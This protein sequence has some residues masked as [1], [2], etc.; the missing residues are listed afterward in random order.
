M[1]ILNITY[2]KDFVL[3]SENLYEP[4]PSNNNDKVISIDKIPISPNDASIINH[5]E[6][7]QPEQW[8]LQTLIIII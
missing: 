5:D 4:S 7:L 2:Q 6:T 1:L 3:I 8:K